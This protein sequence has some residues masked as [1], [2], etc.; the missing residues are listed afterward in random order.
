MSSVGKLSVKYRGNIGRVSAEYRRYGGASVGC[1]TLPS[2]SR[3]VDRA[4]VDAND[5]LSVDSM[6]AVDSQPRVLII[7]KHYSS[8]FGT[9]NKLT[10][11]LGPKDSTLDYQ[12]R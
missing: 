6:V 9:E 11:R 8:R 12:T 4:S 5:R 1:L 2:I 7:V 3:S 10:K